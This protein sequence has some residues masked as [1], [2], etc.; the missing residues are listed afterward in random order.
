M[1]PGGP[2]MRAHGQIGQAQALPFN[3]RQ[4]REAPAAALPPRIRR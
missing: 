1:I 2:V 4:R 3:E